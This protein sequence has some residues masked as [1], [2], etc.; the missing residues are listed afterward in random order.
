MHGRSSQEV[1]QAGWPNMLP[2]ATL[3]KDELH[4]VSTA[5]AGPAS[6][7]VKD[8]LPAATLSVTPVAE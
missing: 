5:S 8:S 4:A 2:L 3:T 7:N 1:R 6:P